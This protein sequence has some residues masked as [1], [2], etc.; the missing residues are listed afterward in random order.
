MNIKKF[1]LMSAV[2]GLG[3]A[4]ALAEGASG[5]DASTMVGDAT[6]SVSAVVTAIG[7][8][9]TAAVALYVGFVGYRKLREG[10]NKA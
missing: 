3:V 4:S 7:G 8:L 10:L 2:C 6:T 1:A 5:F 9:L